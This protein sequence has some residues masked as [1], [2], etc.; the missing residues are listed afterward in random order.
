MGQKAFFFFFFNFLGCAARHVGSLVP[1]PG[2]EPMPLALEARSLNH[3]TAREIR[4]A[5]TTAPQ[6]ASLVLDLRGAQGKRL[7]VASSAPSMEA[8]VARSSQHSTW[9]DPWNMWDVHSTNRVY[10][11]C[12]L[13]A[14]EP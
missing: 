3:W 13:P 5:L 2:I 1:Q 6:R 11:R 14:Q 4:K 12:Q 9:H 7:L 8:Q 10:T